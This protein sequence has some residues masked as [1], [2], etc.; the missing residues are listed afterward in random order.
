MELHGHVAAGGPFYC[1]Q[2]QLSNAYTRCMYSTTAPDV[3]PLV[4]ITRQWAS[5]GAI[6]DPAHLAGQSVFLFGGADDTTVYPAVVDAL[7]TYYSSF[8]DPHSIAYEKH[9]PGTQHTMPTV[10]YGTPCDVSQQPWL[11]VCNYD[12]AGRALGQIYGTLAPAAKTLGGAFLEIHQ[13]DFLPNPAS[14]SVADTGYAY[15]PKSC[16]DGETCRIHVAFHG[17]EQS[18]SLVG[19]AYYKHAGYNEWADTNHVIVVYPQT[20]AS[21]TAPMNPKACWDWWGYDSPDYA[22]K[23]GPQMAMVR[24]ILDHLASTP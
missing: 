6:D 5:A 14:H 23:T 15:V 10:A 2:A 16:A 13:G 19:D 9:R 17:C 18:A 7:E 12:G 4:E 3:A 24:A 11:G 22:K 8:V 1:A 20:V 21:S